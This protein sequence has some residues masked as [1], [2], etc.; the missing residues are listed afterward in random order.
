MTLESARAILNIRPKEQPVFHGHSDSEV[1]AFEQR[2]ARI[3]HRIFCRT[4]V[5]A[6][7]GVRGNSEGHDLV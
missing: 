6:S 3:R 2:L 1:V 4:V 7:A 5:S